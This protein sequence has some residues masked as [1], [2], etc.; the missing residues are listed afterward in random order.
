MTEQTVTLQ[1]T[2]GEITLELYNNHAPKACKNFYELSK[3]GYYDN[4]IFH[5]L[6]KDF[7]IQGG[8]PLGNGRGGESIYGKRFEDEIT[9][10]L[11]H[12]GA[13]ILSMANSGVNSNGSQFFITFGP[14]PWLDGK[15]TIFGRVKS[16]MKVVQKMNAMQTNN[17]RPID[18][19]R[20]IKAT[21]N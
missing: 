15:H 4:T 18:E 5:R 19:I 2:V 11:K 14:T 20:I 16:G 6:I 8:D 9:K 13:G 7:M 17:D 1:T 21:A 12:T 3:R 10:E